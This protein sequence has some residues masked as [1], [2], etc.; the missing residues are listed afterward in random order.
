MKINTKQEALKM[1]PTG[2]IYNP[3]KMLPLIDGDI[4]GAAEVNDPLLPGEEEDI[5]PGIIQNPHEALDRL[6]GIGI[7]IDVYA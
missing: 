4:S 3:S 1:V 5:T 7:N 6:M 2:M